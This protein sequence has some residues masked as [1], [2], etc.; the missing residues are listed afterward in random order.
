M[1]AEQYCIVDMTIDSNLAMDGQTGLTLEQAQEWLVANQVTL[2]TPIT[3]EEHE[4]TV[5]YSIQ[6]DN[7]PAE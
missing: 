5:K 3:I 1:A 2:D 6:P 7:W 4:F